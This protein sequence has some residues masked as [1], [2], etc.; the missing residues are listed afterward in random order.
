MK[1]DITNGFTQIP[2]GFEDVMSRVKLNGTQHNIMH[3]IVR[4]MWGY[5]HDRKPL[6][7][8]YIANGI[9]VSKGQVQ[10]ELP[11][12][13][14]NNILKV[15]KEHTSISSREFAINEDYDS[16]INVRKSKVSVLKMETSGVKASEIAVHQLETSGV[17]QLETSG[18]LEPGNQLNKP[19]NKNINIYRDNDSEQKEET[20]VIFLAPSEEEKKR[21]IENLAKGSLKFQKRKETMGL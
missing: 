15:V 13:I 5:K 21:F 19:L 17:H 12:L 3:F 7:I 18:V 20:R 10:R 8:E 1:V 9:G 14:E 2:N 4:K 11:K 16:W 6:S